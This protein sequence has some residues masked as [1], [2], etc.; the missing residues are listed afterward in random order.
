MAPPGIEPEKEKTCS[1]C[2]RT[3]TGWGNNAAPFPGR[4]CD[5][6][7]TEAVLPA[8]IFMMRAWNER[9]AK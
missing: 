9:R 8:R 5:A 3:Y 2:D 4:C 7:N 1:I 6:C